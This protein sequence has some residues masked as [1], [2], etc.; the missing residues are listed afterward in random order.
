MAK[1]AALTK[2]VHLTRSWYNQVGIVGGITAGIAMALVMMLSSVVLG[3]SIWAGPQMIADTLPAFRDT[4]M[5]WQF[6]AVMVGMGLHLIT[7]VF[8]GYVYAAT[9]PR[10]TVSKGGLVTFGL[11]FGFL[12]MLFMR[13]LVVPVVDPTIANAPQPWFLI[14]HLAYGSVLGLVAIAERKHLA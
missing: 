8:W 11:V 4:N 7:S 13:Y 14:E 6:S 12:V 9:A 3:M 10:L 1:V 2:P 5:G